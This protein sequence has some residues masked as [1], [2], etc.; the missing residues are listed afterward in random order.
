MSKL[1][2]TK[3]ILIHET[4]LLNRIMPLDCAMGTSLKH[5]FGHNFKSIGFEYLS[6]MN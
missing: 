4:V 1:S 3:D 6:I 2:N 5:D